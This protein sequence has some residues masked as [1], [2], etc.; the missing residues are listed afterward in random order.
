MTLNNPVMLKASV[1]AYQQK[2]EDAIDKGEVKDV[3]DQCTLNHHF[4]EYLEEYDAGVYAREMFIPKGVTVVGKIHRYS[5]LSFLLKGKIIVISEFT[6]RIT[7]EAPYTFASPAG[8]KRAF[9]ALEDSILTN[10]HMTRTPYEKNLP[11]IEKEVIAESYSE[12]GME[13]PDVDLFN[14]NILRKE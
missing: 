1:T 12:L 13:E 7:M 6:D 5:H 14:N 10:V 3:L 11:D 4:A 8:S 9:F 2:L